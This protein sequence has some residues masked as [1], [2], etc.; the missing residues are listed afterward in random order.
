[1]DSPNQQAQ[2]KANLTKILTFINENQPPDSQLIL[3]L[4]DNHDIDFKCQ[5]IDL[6]EKENLLDENE[7]LEVYQTF[8]PLIDQSYFGQSELMF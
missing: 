4:E 7:Y 5:I 3:A 6:T 2:D 8:Q 1:M